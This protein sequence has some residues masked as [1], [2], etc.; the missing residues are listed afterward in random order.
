MAQHFETL[1][2]EALADPERAD[3]VTL[4]MA[5]AQS[6]AY[7]PFGREQGEVEELHRRMAAERWDEALDL[8][9]LLLE[10]DPLSIPLRFAYA[11]VL[12]EDNDEVEAGFQRT[13]ANGLLRTVLGSGDGRTAES[14]IQVLDMREMYLVLDVMGLRAIRSQLTQAGT[15]WIDQVGA[16]GRDGERD[17]FFNVSIPQGWLAEVQ[18]IEPGD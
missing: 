17:V 3:F 1:L 9:E 5:Y 7:L 15:E 14:A 10:S 13:F 4:R 16:K 2:E 18:E 8:V 12:E 6:L 11:H